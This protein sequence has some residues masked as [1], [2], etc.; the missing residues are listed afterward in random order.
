M[1]TAIEKPVLEDLVRL[2]LGSDSVF[3]N[4]GRLAGLRGRVPG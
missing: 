4:R 1:S 3:P 2:I